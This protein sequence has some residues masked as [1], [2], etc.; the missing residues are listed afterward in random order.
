MGCGGSKEAPAAAKPDEDKTAAVYEDKTAPAAA[1]ADAKAKPTEDEAAANAEAVDRT[2]VVEKVEAAEAAKEDAPAAT[3]DDLYE[4]PALK[5]RTLQTVTIAI[6][7][8]SS[9]KKNKNN[10]VSIDDIIISFM[11]AGV[12]EKEAVEYLDYVDDD[13]GYTTRE[14]LEAGEKT[15]KEELVVVGKQVQ[16]MMNSSEMTD[17]TDD[18]DEDDDKMKNA[19]A[20][21]LAVSAFLG[22]RT[23]TT[24]KTSV[25]KKTMRLHTL[26][27]ISEFAI[28]AREKKEKKEEK[29]GKPKSMSCGTLGL[30]SRLAVSRKKKELEE[31]TA[32]YTIVEKDIRDLVT[33]AER[34]GELSDLWKKLDADGSGKVESVEV[35]QFVRQRYPLFVQPRANKAAFETTCSGGDGDEWV[36]R[37]EFVAL[38]KNLVYYNK[39]YVVFEDI[40]TGASSTVDVE[41]F[42]K[43]LP[44]LGISLDDPDAAF[45]KADTN[46]GGT[47][48]FN[49]FVV[50]V[51]DH[52]LP[53][54]THLDEP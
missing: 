27:L 46:G 6:S 5:L 47:L 35:N 9:F 51:A 33:N 26:S 43:A 7:K 44:M 22:G 11:D 12:P 41:E 42:K 32:E 21:L 3:D 25:Q 37:N 24:N 50:W 53:V 15:Y 19:T 2:M 14:G 54:L 45:A 31:L 52:D 13:D 40:D 34:K 38:L 18:D 29:D 36:Q 20:K 16:L 49:E 1:S 48:C 17:A 10:D 39:M 23:K 4:L 28:D 8:F 30:I